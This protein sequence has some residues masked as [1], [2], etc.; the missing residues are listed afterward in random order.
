MGNAARFNPR[1]FQRPALPVQAVDRHG[2]T[3]A[4]G[5]LVMMPQ[6]SG[7]LGWRVQEILPNLHPQAPNNALL[8]KLVAVAHMQATATQAINE[9][10]LVMPYEPPV[11]QAEADASANGHNSGSLVEP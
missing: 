2:R 5:D 9:I 8:V 7:D 10:V 3:L 1:S 6:L 4:K 11:E